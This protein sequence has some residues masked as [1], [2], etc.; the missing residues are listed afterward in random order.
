[1]GSSYRRLI[2]VV[3]FSLLA[4]LV[5]VDFDNQ[6]L[7]P[8]TLGEISDREIRAPFSLQLENKQETAKRRLDAANKINPVFTY[9][10][11]LYNKHRSK[12]QKAFINA[13]AN[14]ANIPTIESLLENDLLS[15]S[16]VLPTLNQQQKIKLYS[17][18]VNAQKEEVQAEFA[19]DLD[20]SLS[21]ET[22]SQLQLAEWSVE[23]EKLILFHLNEGFNLFIIADRNKIPRN[24]SSYDVIRIPKTENTE[25]TYTKVDLIKT[26]DEAVAIVTSAVASSEATAE[27]KRATISVLST[28]LQANFSHDLNL[29]FDRKQA[30][31]ER[32]LPEEFIVKK[33]TVIL[34]E[35]DPVT[36]EAFTKIEII[37]AKQEYGFG[38]WGQWLTLS[39]LC[40]MV[41]VS[42]FFFASGFIRKFSNTPRDIEALGFLA[43]LVLLIGRFIVEGSEA[44]SAYV[45]M[46][47][48]PVA[49]WFLT[50]VAGG[51]MLVRILINSETALIWVV[52]TSL[53]LGLVMQQ[54]AL[55]TAFFV[56]SGVVASA[57]LAH[58][59]ERVHLLRAG[60]QAGL[61][62]AA[63]ALL[64]RLAQ[65]Y[66]DNGSFMM[67]ASEQPLWE[68]G[69]AVLGGVLSAFL[70]LALTP[71]FEVFGFVTDY[72][73]LELANLNHPLLHQL[74]L[75]APGTYHHSMAMA[76]LCEAAA[77]AIGANA[78]VARIACYYHDIG[79]SLQPKYF[80]ENQRNGPNPHDRLQPHQ[81]AMI[82]KTH[83]VDGAALGER[84][85]LPKSIMDAIWM[86]HGTSLIKYFYIRALEQ[87]APDE[88]VD[89]A[90]FRH[91]GKRPN[92]REAGIIFLADRVEAACRTLKEPTADDYRKLIQKLVNDG[93]ADGQLEECPLT[94]KEIYIIINS[95]VDT[96]QHIHHHRIEYP[97]MPKD[98]SAVPATPII[99]LEMNNPLREETKK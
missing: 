17:E 21:A 69:F 30:A 76:L 60:L 89:E 87:A 29:T 98:D 63:A 90:L 3:L 58:T 79:K 40:G 45:G 7:R 9:E 53:L 56:I 81:S 28:M 46:G 97:K 25:T 85:N 20:V 16:P 80:I 88:V 64:I 37:L 54:Q 59:K 94:I 99:T 68:V 61:L 65:G 5:M 93:I 74:Q 24:T 55:F 44:L 8:Y 47:M 48:S 78:L 13:R 39:A 10:F 51:A 27:V 70:V 12:I 86:H 72:K 67:T 32:V 66:L 19:R 2:V 36:Q 96:L 26:L 22:M 71:V 18:Q 14:Y 73:L 33:G 11:N 41:V 50:P 23:T 91:T 31:M 82:I 62:N 42:L 57:G 4:A 92:T 43:L 49:L 34:R 52:G 83:V 1:M 75:R 15:G 35:G 84:Y 38:F 95:F 77:E 6:L